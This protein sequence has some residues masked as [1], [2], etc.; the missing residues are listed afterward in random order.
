MRYLIALG[1]AILLVASAWPLL[2]R[3][4]PRRDVGSAPRPAS[5]GE[6]I[7]FAFLT[8]I[9]ISFAISTLLWVFGK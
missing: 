2:R 3:F 6:L 9:A 1:M 5:R 4:A 8:T 7:Y